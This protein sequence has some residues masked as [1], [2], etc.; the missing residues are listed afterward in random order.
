MASQRVEGIGL[1]LAGGG[2][3]SYA[4]IAALEDM[5]RNSVAVGAV[6]GTSMGSLVAT[7]VAAGLPASRIEELM[8]EM[9]ASVAQA[10]IVKTMRRHVVSAVTRQGFL[11]NGVLADQVG[12]ILE[13]AGVRT[14]ADLSMPLALT[15][16]D[17]I[18]GELV[19]FT[20]EDG[21]FEGSQSSSWTTIPGDHDLAIC[22]AAS[23]AYPLVVQ[24]SH[25]LGHTLVD[26]GCRMNLPTPLFDRSSVDAVVGVHM[27]RTYQAVD[28]L[29]I[30]NVMSK[31]MDYGAQQ[32]EILYAQAADVS[33]NIPVDG[34]DTFSPGKGQEI[35]DFARAWLR[36]HPVD[37]SAA[38]PSIFDSVRRGAADYLS[39]LF[40]NAPE[41]SSPAPAASPSA[42]PSSAPESD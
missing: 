27:L 42:P 7:L 19:V 16:V 34:G 21:F 1:A 30:L 26:G 35:I 4:E 3:R 24:P 6:A 22:I 10:G 38:H 25:Y 36:K 40:R 28:D 13:K 5:E 20:G 2:W 39:R 15:A 11:G 37:W 41:P 14:F 31:C 18:S 33:V 29:S 23:G 9:D 17:I 32:L 8:L 12:P